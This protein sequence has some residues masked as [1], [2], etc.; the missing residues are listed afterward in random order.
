MKRTYRTFNEENFCSEVGNIQWDEVCA[1][2]D[3]NTSLNL[4]MDLFR[5]IVNNHAPLKKFT[6]K[7]NSAPW[8]DTELKSLMSQRDEAKKAAVLLGSPVDRKLY[9]TLRN[10][11]TKVNRVKKRKYY[12]KRISDS[13]TNHKQIW[14][15]LNEIMGKKIYL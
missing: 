13:G 8:V 3:V 1:I 9:C 10:Y 6:V 15:V 5:R 14:S 4:F 7:D 12:Q 2:D 11:V